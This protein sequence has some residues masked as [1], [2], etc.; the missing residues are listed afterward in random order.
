[1]PMPMPMPLPLPLQHRQQHL[2]RH[3]QEQ[4]NCNL[5]SFTVN[6]QYKLANLLLSLSEQPS[7]GSEPRDVGS[8]LI[9]SDL[10]SACL[11]GCFNFFLVSF[12]CFYFYFY[13]YFYVRRYFCICFRCLPQPCVCASLSRT[14]RFNMNPSWV[15]NEVNKSIAV[16]HDDLLACCCCCSCCCCCHYRKKRES[17]ASDRFTEYR[18]SISL[19]DHDEL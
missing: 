8:L 14:L 10:I 13:F 3:R 12:G 4:V 1:M 15:S 18:E 2:Q 19:R 5:T 16:G 7:E 9:S 17:N 11:L 6:F